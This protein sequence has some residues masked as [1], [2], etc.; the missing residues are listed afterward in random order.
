MARPLTGYT[1]WVKNWRGGESGDKDVAGGDGGSAPL[2]PPSPPPVLLVYLVYLVR[3]LTSNL[4]T[5]VRFPGGAIIFCF[6]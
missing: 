6:L 3:S 2:S 1:K 4:A 5:G